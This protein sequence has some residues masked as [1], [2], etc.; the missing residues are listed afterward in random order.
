MRKKKYLG[1]KLLA[2]AIIAAVVF[3]VL[4]MRA[5]MNYGM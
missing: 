1:W 5:W 3:L 2:L 4:L